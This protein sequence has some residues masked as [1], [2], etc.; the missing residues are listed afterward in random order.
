MADNLDTIE[1]NNYDNDLPKGKT[2][3]INSQVRKRIEDLMEKKRLKSL[4]DDSED[5][6]I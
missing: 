2:S 6:D 1:D 3:E 5:W 4:L